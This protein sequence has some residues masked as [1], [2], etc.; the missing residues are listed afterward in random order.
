V[1]EQALRSLYDNHV[2]RKD[3]H[4]KTFVKAE[5]LNL[6]RKPDADPRVIQ[7]RSPRYN[8]E[9]GCYIKSCEHMIYNAIDKMW[10]RST[11]MK[12]KNA[13]QRGRAM[14]AT[15]D[16]FV[17]PVA[18]SVDASRFDQHVSRA[19]LV[20]E[21][22]V[23]RTLFRDQHL[24]E[25]LRWQLRNI[26]HVYATD[27]KITYK[28]DG[29]RMSGDM[30]TSLGNVMLMCLMMHSYARTKDFKIALIND[31][32]DCVLVMERE[33]VGQLADLTPWFERLGMVMVVDP[34]V[35][36]LEHISFCQTRAINVGGGV[37]RMVRDPRECLNKDLVSVK[38]INSKADLDFYRRAIGMCGLSL[39]GDLPVY[40]SFYTSLIRG[41]T[42]RNFRNWKGKMRAIELETGMQYLAL[43][44]AVK[45]SEP[46]SDSRVSFYEAFGIL[47]D[48]QESLE[49]SYSLTW[50]EWEKPKCVHEFGNLIA[51]LY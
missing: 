19:L 18:V 1:Y 26:G 2:E 36:V 32:D 39:A 25:L 44:M 30:N 16:E 50:S 9:V 22:S 5:K 12:G 28:V 43:G 21:H 31:G 37:Y 17:H 34:H 51:G 15:W 8:L 45:H 49:E 38:N 23:Y 10:G 27:G 33:N 35:S 14:K 6:S 24:S 3:A 13:D 7:P 41:T 46:S 20:L 42:E 40:T 48:V 47:P 4:L 11:V 29:S